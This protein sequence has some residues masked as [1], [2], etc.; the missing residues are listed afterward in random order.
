LCLPGH[1][2]YL[3]VTSDDERCAHEMEALDPYAHGAHV[4]VATVLHADHQWGV[5]HLETDSGRLLTFVAP[6]K[7]T[8]LQEG[9]LPLVGLAE[10]GPAEQRPHGTMPA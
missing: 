3:S 4:T 10:T 5:L 7:I 9:E 8:D 6:E 1:N 2:P